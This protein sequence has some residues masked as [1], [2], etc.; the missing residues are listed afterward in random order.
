VATTHERIGGLDPELVAAMTTQYH[1]QPLAPQRVSIA[2]VV[3]FLSS[4]SAS[5]EG[6]PFIYTLALR[7]QSRP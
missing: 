1:L 2:E 7:R 3:D 5:H 6:T 4:P